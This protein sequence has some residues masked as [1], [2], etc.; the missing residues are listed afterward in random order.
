MQKIYRFN[1]NK[2]IVYMNS[3]IKYLVIVFL[4]FCIPAL[5][6][7]AEGDTFTSTSVEGVVIKYKVISELDKTCQ[8]GVGEAYVPAI[9]TSYSGSVTIPASVNGY[10]II[11]IGDWAF[12]PSCNFSAISIPNSVTH[13]GGNAFSGCSNFSSIVLPEQLLTIGENAFENCS[14]LKSI[15]IPSSIASIR[16]GAFKGCEN[17]VSVYLPNSINSISAETFY[18]CSSLENI[19]LPDCISSI[20]NS[21]FWGCSSLKSIKFPNSLS[22]IEDYLCVSCISLVSID[23]PETITVI[24]KSAFAGCNN[25]KEL[26]FSSSLTLI[27][28]TAFEG[29]SSL[30]YIYLPASLTSIGANAFYSCSALKTVESKIMEPFETY[31]FTTWSGLPA[32]RILYVPSGTK[33]KYIDCY[34]WGNFFKE[35]I[36]KVETF[37]LSVTASGNGS[38]SFSGSSIRNQ[39]NTF[40]V[41]EG[42]S[43]TITFTPD[44]GYRIKSVKL[45]NV[46]VTS[47]LVNNQY[48][49]SNISVNTNVEVEFEAIDESPIIS[50]ADAN[51]K[52]ICV[53]NWDKNGDGELSEEE[54][55]SATYLGAVFYENKT[56]TLF[57]EFQYF[58]GIE[59]LSSAFRNCSNLKKIIIPSSVK[60]IGK[61]AFQNCSALTGTLIIPSSV[62]SIGESAFEECS[63]FTGALTIPESVTS[64]GERA[65]LGCVGFNGS[66]SLPNS[67]TSIGK[68]AFFGCSGFT[69][70]L[71]IPESVTSIG[72]W[73]FQ[74]CSGFTNTITIPNSVISIGYA[75]FWGCSNI[76]KVISQILSPIQIDV[77]VFRGISSDAVLQVPKGTKA[78]Y[79][80][81][82]GWTKYFN[83]IIEEGDDITYSL[84]ISATGNGCVTYGETTIKN[85]TKSFTIKEGASATISFTPDTG[86]KIKS[87]KLNT[88][89][90]TS[91]IK[92]GQYIISNINSDNTLEV[93]YEAIMHTLS[94]T[95]SGNGSA[96]YNGTA[97]RGKTQTFTVNEGTSA[98]VTF[99]SDAGYRIASVKLNNV[100][101]TTSVANN[102]YTISNITAN[103]TLEVTFE[104]IPT[105][106]LS[107]T[108]SGNGSATYNGTAVR[109]KTQTFTV[110]EGTSATVTFAPDAGYRI[111]SVKMNNTDVTASVANNSYTISNIMTNTTLAV[112]F[113]VI[114]P[115]TYTF[116]ISAAGNGSVTYD[117]NTVRGKSSSFTVVEGTNAIVSFS[118]DDGNRLKSVKLGNID[119][120]SSVVNNQYTI[121]NIQANTSLEVIFEA[122]PTYTLNIL[123]TGNG[124]VS[125]DGTNIRNQSQNFTV[126]EG[127]SAILTFTPDAGY[128]VAN[129]KKDNT[130]VTGQ[131]S[132]G[133][134][135]INNITSNTSVEVTFEAIPP[136]TYTLTIKSTGNGAATYEGTSVRGKSSQFTITEGSYATVTFTPDTDNRIKSVKVNSE[137]VT[138]SVTDG[139]YTISSIKENTNVEVVFEAIPTYSLNILATGNG[140]VGYDGTNIRNQSQ[141]F[142]IKEGGSAVLTF[143]PDAGYRVAN[144]KK[145]NTDVTGQISDGKLTINNITSNTSV[146]VTFEAI[147]PTT[148]TLTIKSTGN[149]TATYDGTSVR[150]KSSQF[151]VTEG[152]YA[153]VTFTPDTDNRIKSVKVNSE[154]VTSSI[155]DG[156]YTI[157]SIKENTNVEV[158]FEAIPTYSLNILATGNGKVGYDG[159]NIRNQSQSFTIKEGGSAVLT[160]TPDAGYRVANVKKDNT[161]VTGQIS[162]G[163]LTINNITSNTS[164]EVTFEA[165]PPTTYT[166]TIKSTGNGTA[167][168][169]GTTVR[170]KSSQFTITEGTYATVT[171]TPDTG[172]RIKDVK[173]NNADVTSSVVDNQYTINKIS[174][175]TSLEVEFTEDFKEITS[176]DVNYKVVSY[177]Q[178]TINLESGDYGLTLTVPATVTAYDRVWN[179]VGVEADA[180]NTNLAAIIWNPEVE[181]NGVVSNPNLLLYVKNRQYAPSTI[182][183]VVVN[184]EAEE[185]TL[186][187]AQSGNNF[188]C[189]QAF[190][191]KKVSYEHHYGMTTGYNTCQGW[192]TIVLPFDVA[193][194]LNATAQ[195]IVPYAIW[196]ESSSLRTFWLYNLTASGWQAANSIKANTPYIISMPNNENYDA[197]Y[198]IT[199]NIQ[200]IGNNVQIKASDNLS[201]VQSGNK[202]FVPNYQYQETS[203]SIYA[204]NVNNQW[205]TN[206]SPEAEG[207]TF[208]RS[209]RAVRPFEAY[210]TVE[211]GTSAPNYIPV[212]GDG[213]PT[214]IDA[215]LI[216]SEGVNSEKWYSLDGRKLQG[217]PTTKGLYIVNG[218]K[219]VV[220]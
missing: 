136:T 73:A 23:F 201:A 160:F 115:T 1:M 69:G 216:N 217:K 80:D 150:D 118:A 171:F 207:S 47:S 11:S 71:T 126:K 135:T 54:A 182:K 39:T 120:T 114:P 42:S 181:F 169:D 51:I 87:I 97:V 113:E 45:N 123:A 58:I 117:G 49:I 105:Y 174:A 96:T 195:E 3:Y 156:K 24:G 141:S 81:Y 121:S 27:G 60:I 94:I 74:D 194:I 12:F 104:A 91:S 64:I 44:A 88:T 219:V 134:L 211:G 8:V 107:I 192:E 72:G 196:D 92:D 48:M 143:T 176:A 175:D 199:G 191:A 93:E 140:K 185:I 206:T 157:S 163:K 164:V 109:G 154:D 9:P 165:I 65:F 98:T 55:A 56:I 38:A 95:A 130:D 146:E 99:D 203:S 62:T 36:E 50:F 43:A 29:C 151:T 187:D 193:T 197:S 31:A 76:N 5:V 111:A 125:Y 159:T 41:N 52:A 152:T 218:R 14:K 183:N 133:K 178:Q 139:K 7:G 78:Q 22:K 131:I 119:I 68:H 147:P 59:D 189:P 33:E 202:S 21:A 35:V 25:L 180:L 124:K 127:G 184:G 53:S 66:L 75:A 214:G 63:G 100:D 208:V 220:K 144:V 148:Y 82:T 212:F 149:G 102:S 46:D 26:N 155:S 173:V 61:W 16:N 34:G 2:N 85:Q 162:D 84:S 40:T 110:N 20:G 215:K 137:D 138:S 204:L 122:I 142:T 205:N 37:S 190:T 67:L 19:N 101:V 145:D 200:F 10:S 210:L 86:Y 17:L 161:D 106:S 108:A 166:L 112:T 30:A 132:N 79:M 83:K 32:E 90:V 213:M 198:N 172:Y 4:I 167:T 170:G 57:E 129:V 153:T 18:N 168:Y 116:T 77:D 103:T 70:N 28:A 188:Y 158:V 177:E 13:I 179:V 6:L 209:L 89:D 186:V 128:R 15:D